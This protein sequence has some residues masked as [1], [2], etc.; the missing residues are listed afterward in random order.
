[1]PITASAI[2]RLREEN[3]GAARTVVTIFGT[4]VS[5]LIE[6]GKNPEPLEVLRGKDRALAEFRSQISQLPLN[7]SA[8]ILR[9][10]MDAKAHL[11]RR[12]PKMEA[13]LDNPDTKLRFKDRYSDA[14]LYLRSLDREKINGLEKRI[15]EWRLI[16]QFA[17][18]KSTERPGVAVE[19]RK[20][21]R[22]NTASI[23]VVDDGVV[24][25]VR[26]MGKTPTELTY[27]LR[28]IPKNSGLH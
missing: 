26:K 27:N 9:M 8:S 20:F 7:Q 2:K 4:A 18:S 21:Y 22:D 5:P 17:S 23:D 16:N 24:K 28:L 11:E 13:K 3:E 25:I 1:M 15:N 12:I 19:L 14:N 6:L 10:A